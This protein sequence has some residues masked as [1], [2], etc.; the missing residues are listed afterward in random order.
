MVSNIDVFLPKLSDLLVNL[1][2]S[3]SALE[4]LLGSLA[5][6]PALQA[7]ARQILHA[8]SPSSYL[9]FAHIGDVLAMPVMLEAI[10]DIWVRTRGAPGVLTVRR[11]S[12]G[13]FRSALIETIFA[14]EELQGHDRM[15]VWRA[16]DEST[17]L[18]AR[19]GNELASM[20]QIAVVRNF[21]C[22]HLTSGADTLYEVGEVAVDISA[23]VGTEVE[24]Q[25]RWTRADCLL[26]PV[27]KSDGRYSQ[28]YQLDE[29]TG[30]VLGNSA[31]AP[32]FKELARAINVKS[33][34]TRTRI[35]AQAFS[36]EDMQKIIELLES[37]VPEELLCDY[38]LS[39]LLWKV[40]TLTVIPA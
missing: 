7:G 24:F 17:S 16:Y 28:P 9:T 10:D 27:L 23:L 33:N 4:A 2:E 18:R 12:R 5:M 13:D 20:L 32:S 15:P 21:G 40:P 34:F 30:V 14:K 22:L 31:R 8:V 26:T 39:L 37:Q 6:G 38:G 29:V 3:R 19:L 11:K 36:I 1:A 35:H 25:L